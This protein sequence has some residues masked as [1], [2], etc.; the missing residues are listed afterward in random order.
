MLL[1]PQVR[2]L[3]FVRPATAAPAYQEGD[4]FVC[5]VGSKHSYFSDTQG[6]SLTRH[7]WRCNIHLRLRT[8]DRRYR[9]NNNSKKTKPKH[10]KGQFERMA[11]IPRNQLL[12]LIFQLFRDQPRWGIKPL[13]ERTQ[14]PE[15]YLKEVLSEVAFLN[16]TGEFSS[17]WELKE[18]YKDGLVGGAA[19]TSTMG[20]L[21]SFGDAD[22]KMESVPDGDKDE[23]E[24]E[25]EDMEDVS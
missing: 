23:D 3:K 18:M 25:D 20:E 10:A 13:R 19:G 4:L 7:Q 2:L 1:R 8:W 5:V 15:V 6:D 11:R 24:D 14:Q 9:N 12:D 21:I 17:L 16:K 22:I